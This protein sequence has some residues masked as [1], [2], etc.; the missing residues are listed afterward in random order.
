MPT[1][2]TI[3]DRIKNANHK[4]NRTDPDGKLIFHHF[5][6][7]DRYAVDFADD[8]VREGWQQFDTDQDAWYFGLWVNPKRLATLCYA[9]GDWTLCEFST[10][11]IYNAEITRLGEVYGEGFILKEIHVGTGNITTHRQDRAEFLVSQ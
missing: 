4:D 2:N 9:E 7:A 5:L 6:S 11:E 3:C 1:I 8:R 10:V